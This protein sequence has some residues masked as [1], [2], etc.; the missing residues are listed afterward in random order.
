MRPALLIVLFL[1]ANSVLAQNVDQAHPGKE[2][3]LTLAREFVDLPPTVEEAIMEYLDILEKSLLEE[4]RSEFRS[5]VLSQIRF[6]VLEEVMVQALAEQFTE[7]ELSAKI[8]FF[9]S[10]EG[11]SITRK[12]GAYQLKVA[13]AMQEELNRV[14]EE[15]DVPIR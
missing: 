9:G 2:Q 12:M 14:F 1:T 5:Y 6:D 15:G 8:Q 11:R 3:R 13:K 4:D 10:P 7:A